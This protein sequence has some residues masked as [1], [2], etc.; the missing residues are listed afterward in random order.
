MLRRFRK[1]SRALLEGI[2]RAVSNVEIATQ[3]LSS[4]RYSDPVAQSQAWHAE[5]FKERVLSSFGR[6]QLPDI[7]RFDRVQDVYKEL[8]RALECSTHE[9]Q[10][11]VRRLNS[12]FKPKI[13][14][15]NSEFNRLHGLAFKLAQVLRSN[16]PLV[17]QIE[18][19]RRNVERL[20]QNQGSARQARAEMLK[21]EDQIAQLN[22]QLVEIDSQLKKVHD[23]DC[24]KKL[25]AIRTE[26]KAIEG[27]LSKFLGQFNRPLRK[28]HK[29][30]G[31]GKVSLRPESLGTLRSLIED[32]AYILPEN[33]NWTHV[34]L[35]LHDIGRLL[36][37][38]K[39]LLEKRKERKVL[40][41]IGTFQNGFLKQTLE[42]F[43]RL[44]KEESELMSAAEVSGF[45]RNGLNLEASRRRLETEIHKLEQS[46]AM[47]QMKIAE[48]QTGL[49][50]LS[51]NI[52]ESIRALFG[53]NVSI[54]I[55]P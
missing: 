41:A 51:R 53:V 30:V 31:E 9:G 32:S 49:N 29:L 43:E 13:I 27:R 42:E 3:S 12:S 4:T 40:N 35:L 5:R 19:A 28:L 46:K 33:A 25:E 7:L 34:S 22:L 2:N 47:L 1:D 24:L 6:I 54:L 20:A 48:L 37:D 26:I 50:E 17:Q 8:V 36:E 23:C 16:Q 11:T 45:A 14:E 44:R 18:A 10:N 55:T 52:E 39:I 21:I 38:G 15:L